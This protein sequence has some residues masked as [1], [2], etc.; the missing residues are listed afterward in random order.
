MSNCFLIIFYCFADVI[1]CKTVIST[2][3]YTVFSINGT[4]AGFVVDRSNKK[5]GAKITTP[6]FTSGGIYY[7]S[8]TFDSNNIINATGFFYVIDNA[9]ITVTSISPNV[10]AINT[11]ANLTVTGTNFLNSPELVCLYGK[12]QRQKLTAVYVS[13]T[14]VVCKLPAQQKSIISDLVLSFVSK[15]RQNH[16][17]FK[18]AHF[19]SVNGPSVKSARFAERLGSVKLDFYERATFLT[20]GTTCQ[21]VFPYHYSK[22]GSKGECKFVADK[23]L[24]IKLVDGPTLT[25]EPLYIDLTKIIIKGAEYTVHVN[26]SQNITITSPTLAPDIELTGP[27]TVGKCV[28]LGARIHW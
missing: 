4:N 3:F 10:T 24:K 9:T 22:F 11:A 13:A 19:I 23:I 26:K 1:N 21:D 17:Y 12:K 28:Y 5:T 16:L 2:N 20:T 18:A 8:C 27:S 7:I 14:S 15:Q 25:P 6:T